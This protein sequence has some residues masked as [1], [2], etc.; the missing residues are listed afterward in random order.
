MKTAII[1]GFTAILLSIGIVAFAQENP[2]DKTVTFTWT[3]PFERVNG[4]PMSADEIA[5]YTLRC[6][7]S[8][9][10]QVQREITFPAPEEPILS[11]LMSELLP[12]YG[13]FNCELGV[14][15]TLGLRSDFVLAQGEPLTFLPPDPKGP[16]DVTHSVE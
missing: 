9:N 3:P 1:L 7:E 10:R 12:G 2:N 5:T 13:T 15:D 14:T 6:F 11:E 8:Q 4:E 16:T